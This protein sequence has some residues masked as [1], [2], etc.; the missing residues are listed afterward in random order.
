MESHCNF[1]NKYSFDLEL[2]SDPDAK[3]LTALGVGQ[4]EWKGV[5]Y[6]DRTTFLVSPDGVIKKVYPQVNPEGHEKV[7]LEDLKK[8]SL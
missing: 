3:L 8:F 2:L 4:K 7:I 1:V 6:W 5:L